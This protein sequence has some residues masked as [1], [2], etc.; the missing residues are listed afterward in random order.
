MTSDDSVFDVNKLITALD[1][2]DNERF[3]SLNKQIIEE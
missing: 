1:N 3:M 2:E